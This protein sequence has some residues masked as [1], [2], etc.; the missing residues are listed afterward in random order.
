MTP[1]S[2]PGDRLARQALRPMG[3]GALALVVAAVTA[4]VTGPEGPSAPGALASG[5]LLAGAGA[6]AWARSGRRPVATTAVVAGI[7]LGLLGARTALA[8]TM[9]ELPPFL[10]GAGAVVAAI[11]IV[12]D[13]R[14]LLGLGLLQA[15]A[16]LA[17]PAPDAAPFRH[18]LIAT[19][20]A[21]PIPRLDGP[22]LLGLATIGLGLMAS[23]LLPSRPEAARGASIG[24]LLLTCGTL[25]A[26]AADLPSLPGLCGSGD[27]VDAGWMIVAMLA[28]GVVA[29]AGVAL[30]DRTTLAIGGVTLVLAG[31][32]GTTLSGQPVWALAAGGP[33]VGTLVWLD[34]RGLVWSHASGATSIAGQD[35]RAP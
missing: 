1:V 24:G 31:L 23:A 18:C 5:A 29:A 7:A 30:R 4:A 2:R 9:A 34:R 13:E 17:L 26:K 27:G 10:V 14:R 6:I 35:G 11:G 25:L 19:D 12:V 8:P 16:G 22:L 3:V 15:A 20:L 32:V 33:T 21:V 28:G